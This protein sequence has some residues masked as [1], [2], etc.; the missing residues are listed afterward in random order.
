MGSRPAGIGAAVTPRPRSGPTAM[1]PSSLPTGI[2]AVT[3]LVAGSIR[4]TVPSIELATQTAP[5]PV[6]MLLAPRP[7]RIEPAIR[8][9]R[10]VDAHDGVVEE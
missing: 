5:L 7:T 8:F 6:A 4:E 2:V 9:R 3:E 1:S 10:G